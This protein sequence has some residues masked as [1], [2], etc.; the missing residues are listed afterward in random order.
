MSNTLAVIQKEAP[1]ALG[2]TWGWIAEEVEHE[3]V[4]GKARAGLAVIAWNSVEE[5]TASVVAS[6]EIQQA[7]G[8]L[9]GEV[10][11]IDIV[12]LNLEFGNESRHILIDDSVTLHSSCL[13]NNFKRFDAGFT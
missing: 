9:T 7:L 10:K 1:A 6:P 4:E 5:Q 3:K 12:S 13:S 11:H 2:L 8:A